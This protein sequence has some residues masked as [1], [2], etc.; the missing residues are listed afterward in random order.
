LPFAFTQQNGYKEIKLPRFPGGTSIN[1]FIASH[2]KREQA[3][4]EMNELRT[5]MCKISQ[6]SIW[7]N[8][9]KAKPI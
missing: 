4:N 8:R 1:T 2:K 6:A 3:M 9:S 7:K 5:A